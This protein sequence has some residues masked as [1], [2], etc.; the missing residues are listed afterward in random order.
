MVATLLDEHDVVAG[1]REL[2]ADDRSARTGADDD[3]IGIELLD[4]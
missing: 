3:D 4:R 2:C 1:L